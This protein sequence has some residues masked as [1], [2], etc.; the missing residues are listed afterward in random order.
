MLCDISRAGRKPPGMPIGTRLSK[1][2]CSSRCITDAAQ[3]RR[4]DV[5]SA[6]AEVLPT[7]Q[8]RCRVVGRIRHDTGIPKEGKHLGRRGA[9]VFGQ[10]GKQD[11]YQVAF[12]LSVSTWSSSSAK[13]VPTVSAGSIVPGWRASQPN[14]GSRGDRFQAKSEIAMEA[15]TASGVAQEIPAGVVLVGCRLCPRHDLPQMR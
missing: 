15:N 4:R 5:G 11:N 12:S 7:I 8:K 1:S 2:Y 13:S 9:A 10:I 6:A 3:E 14:R